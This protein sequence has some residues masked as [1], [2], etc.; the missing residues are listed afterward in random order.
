MSTE[1]MSFDDLCVVFN[2]KP[3]NRLLTSAETADVLRTTK[4]ALDFKRF[5]GGGP[6][7]FRND[8]SRRVLYSE[9]DVLAYLWAGMRTSTSEQPARR[10]AV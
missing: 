7:Y 5:K 9:R 2:Y 4:S 3:K 10:A 8:D 1:Q 6:R